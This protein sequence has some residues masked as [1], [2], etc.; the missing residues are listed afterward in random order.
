MVFGEPYPPVRIDLMRKA[1]T[2]FYASAQ[3]QKYKRGWS[4][5]AGKAVRKVV[6]E[7]HW[8]TQFIYEKR[9]H[10]IR[11]LIKDGVPKS[12]RIWVL[13]DWSFH[14]ALV[15]AVALA[16]LRFDGKFRI[17]ELVAIAE[18]AIGQASTAVNAATSKIVESS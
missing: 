8:K 14:D 9:C 15:I 3:K 12:L 6:N 2:A 7:E 13:P 1:L 17:K 4:T 5:K 18:R 16:P 10:A 11:N